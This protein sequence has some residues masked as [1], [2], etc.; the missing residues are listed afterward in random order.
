MNLLSYNSIDKFNNQNDLSLWNFFLSQDKFKSNKKIWNILWKKYGKKKLF[1]LF[2]H[3]CE[4]EDNKQNL[5]GFFIKII[6]DKKNRKKNKKQIFESIEF[7]NE[8]LDLFYKFKWL[9][10][11]NE[12]NKKKYTKKFEEYKEVKTQKRKKITKK[13]GKT[14]INTLYYK[15]KST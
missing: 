12:D 10:F 1:T 5:V 9:F 11:D 3:V 7:Q 2:L 13:I 4:R 8:V 15:R 14:I 6:F